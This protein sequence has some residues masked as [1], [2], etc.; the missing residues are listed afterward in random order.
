VVRNK[1]VVTNISVVSPEPNLYSRLNWKFKRKNWTKEKFKVWFP[2]KASVS[3]TDSVFVSKL[4]E[5]VT[6]AH[7]EEIL[8]VKEQVFEKRKIAFE[9]RTN[10]IFCYEILIGTYHMIYNL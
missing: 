4:N 7:K 8:K 1:S 5:F 2:K 10:Q 6:V 9:G 3:D